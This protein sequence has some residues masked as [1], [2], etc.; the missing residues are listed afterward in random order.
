[1]QGYTGKAGVGRGWLIGLLQVGKPSELPS[2]KH[3]Y[4]F[5]FRGKHTT[6]TTAEI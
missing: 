1:M 5:F 3:L 2:S 6:Y 4:L